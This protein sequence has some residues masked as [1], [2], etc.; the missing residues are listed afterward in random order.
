MD[1]QTDNKIKIKLEIDIPTSCGKPEINVS[2]SSPQ[3]NSL[4]TPT[5]VGQAQPEVAQPEVPQRSAVALQS[6]QRT[7]LLAAGI[8]VPSGSA[9]AEWD[10]TANTGKVCASGEA[11]DFMGNIARDV[12]LKIEPGQPVI[13]PNRP[14]GPVIGVNQANGRW[15]AFVDGVTDFPNQT[16]HGIFCWADFGN[17]YIE[18]DTSPFNPI[19]TSYPYCNY[20]FAAGSTSMSASA[21]APALDVLPKAWSVETMGFLRKGPGQTQRLLGYGHDA[22]SCR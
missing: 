10:A 4:A 16:L 20:P 6:P 22:Q 3:V 13:Y 19:W 21:P 9:W 11:I 12:I 1:N 14:S 2:E 5:P 17:G 18:F 7:S 15:V 8:I